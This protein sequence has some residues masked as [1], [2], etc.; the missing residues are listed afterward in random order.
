MSGMVAFF[1]RSTGAPVIAEAQVPRPAEPRTLIVSSLY[2]TGWTPVEGDGLLRP[3]K[4]LQLGRLDRYYDDAASLLPAA[5][6]RH[7]EGTDVGVRYS[8]GTVVWAR[9][10]MFRTASGQSVPALS[11]GVNAPGSDE[12]GTPPDDA[13]YVRFLESLV[14]LLNTCRSLEVTLGGVPL[15][16]RIDALGRETGVER[17]FGVSRE[18]H[19]LV[20]GPRLPD[21]CRGDE[22]RLLIERLVYRTH[23]ELQSSVETFDRPAELNKRPGATVVVGPYVS[24]MFGMGREE[25]NTAFVSV[26]QLVASAARLRYIGDEAHRNL[27]YFRDAQ[28]RPHGRALPD[29]EKRRILGTVADALGDLE[30]ELSFSVEAAADISLLVPSVRV[31]SYHDTLF[32]QMGLRRKFRIVSRMLRRLARSIHAETTSLEALD[33]H[34]KDDRRRRWEAAYLYLAT[35]PLAAALALGYLGMNASEVVSDRSMWAGEYRGAY[36]AIGGVVL[37]AVVMPGIV[38][39]VQIVRRAVQAGRRERWERSERVTMRVRDWHPD[40]R[41]P[42][43]APGG[44]AGRTPS[45]AGRARR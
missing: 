16:Q 18:C 30:L 38:W 6:V 17:P 31:T 9:L 45:D 41:R 26:A 2:G 4:H 37:G 24:L 27:R 11:L 3:S 23:R 22:R 12:R 39:L 20:A 25:G 29:A 36:L 44:T 32:V 10:W 34:G 13:S 33:R 35:I 5:T 1:R 43:V 7:W 19:Q 28:R 42:A 15:E 40:P 8:G 14:D 21:W